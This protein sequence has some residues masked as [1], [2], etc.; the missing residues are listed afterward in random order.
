VISGLAC[1]QFW[2]LCASFLLYALIG[3]VGGGVLGKDMLA[4]AR[5]ACNKRA[6]VRNNSRSVDHVGVTNYV[7]D[8]YI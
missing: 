2:V 6:I 1:F 3:G 8:C 4:R 5:R 7:T